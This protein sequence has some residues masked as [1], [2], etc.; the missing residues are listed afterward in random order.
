MKKSVSPAGTGS[1]PKIRKLN[2]SDQEL[3]SRLK[4]TFVNYAAFQIRVAKGAVNDMN[5][6]AMT[7]GE[8]SRFFSDKEIRRAVK[9]GLLVEKQIYMPH[10][11]EGHVH[12]TNVL[13]YTGYLASQRGYKGW[14]EALAAR[15]GLL[16]WRDNARTRYHSKS[17]RSCGS[18]E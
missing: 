17:E 10:G 7:Q 12:R 15:L 18:Q 5:L 11:K 4:S 8:V 16:K 9:L 1:Q 3:A 6:K 14:F 2:A 13:G